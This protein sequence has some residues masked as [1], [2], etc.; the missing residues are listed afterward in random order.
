MEEE[1]GISVFVE[2]FYGMGTHS[3]RFADSDQRKAY[4]CLDGF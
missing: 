2:E 3:I 4:F 1:G